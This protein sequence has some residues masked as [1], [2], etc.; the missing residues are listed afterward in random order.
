MSKSSNK[1][2][3]E[4][5]KQYITTLKTKPKRR[6]EDIDEYESFKIDIKGFKRR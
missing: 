2:K 5:L 6:K 3:V 4:C 1:L